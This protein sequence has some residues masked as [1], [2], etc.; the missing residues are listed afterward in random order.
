M[1]EY[2]LHSDGM[3]K[4]G[5]VLTK[6]LFVYIQAYAKRFQLLD[7]VC[8]N[9]EVYK[10]TKAKNSSGRN[11]RVTVR[12]SPAILRQVDTCSRADLATKPTFFTA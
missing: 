2:S 8:L 9:S 1:I 3:S 4:D 6:R 5:F 7:C 12:G 11:V 10:I